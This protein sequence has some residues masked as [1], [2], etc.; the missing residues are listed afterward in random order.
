MMSLR[1]LLLCYFVLTLS[2][3]LAWAR[4]QT[5][6]GLSTPDQ[7]KDEFQNVP[8]KNSDRQAA[9][10]SLFGKMGAPS[11]D[12]T[13][14]N[15]KR[16]ENV[17]VRKKGTAEGLIVVGAHYDKVNEGCGALDNWTGIVTIAH[18]YRYLK[19]VPVKKTIVF[20]A[21]GREEDGLIGSA[22]MADDIGKDTAPQYCAMINIDSL[23]LAVPQVMDNTSSP[24]LEALTERI[25]KD[26]HIGFSHAMINGG[27]A[28]SSSFLGKKIPA[29]TIH[30][31]TNEWPRILHSSSDQPAKVDPQ[32]VYLGYRLALALVNRLDSA[33]CDAYKR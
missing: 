9:V 15:Y 32:S 29:L 7:F 8:C 16:V 5:A 6:N 23:G 19:N 13:I 17:V 20:V 25:A 11:S 3:P 14:D 1:K 4:P 33:A 28:D 10:L 21:F 26:M 30:G 31:M 24:Q 27:D 22:A 12:I 2:V 18:L